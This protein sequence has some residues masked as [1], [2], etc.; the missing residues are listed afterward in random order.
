MEIIK[1]DKLYEYFTGDAPVSIEGP[2]FHALNSGLEHARAT[3]L[4]SIHIVGNTGVTYFSHTLIGRNAVF[5][6][7][8]NKVDLS[9]PDSSATPQINVT[10][11]ITLDALLFQLSAGGMEFPGIPIQGPLQF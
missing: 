3:G 9:D 6:I 7:Y 11:K 4:R 5:E 8:N 10:T 2:D 1:S